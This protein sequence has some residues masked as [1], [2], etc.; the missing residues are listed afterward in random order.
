L[1]K[2]LSQDGIYTWYT[3]A[4]EILAEFDINEE[5]IFVLDKPFKLIK[6]S[7]KRVVKEKY[8]QGDLF[9]YS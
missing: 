4:R 2:T 1:N 5:D 8:D 9:L 3:F 7:T 6:N